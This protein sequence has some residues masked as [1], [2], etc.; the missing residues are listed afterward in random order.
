MPNIRPATR[1]DI[2]RLLDLQQQ[3]WQFE[4][5]DHF[6]RQN[7]RRL[8]ESFLDTPDHGLILVVETLPMLPQGYLIAC[9]QFS[10]EYG[11]VCATLDELFIEPA[12][13]SRGI[14]TALLDRLAADVRAQ[15]CISI[16]L[17]VAPGNARAIGLYTRHGFVMRSKYQTMRKALS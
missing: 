7:N 14:G 16:D 9:F 5:I 17:E 11:G 10:F 1:A 13:R 12:L 8:L 2:D 15:G 6:D 3:Y 4:Q